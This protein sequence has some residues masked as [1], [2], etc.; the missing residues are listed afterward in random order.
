MAWVAWV[1]CMTCGAVLQM[2]LQQ[3][4]YT[5]E[6]RRKARFGALQRL[7]EE[8]K[9]QTGFIQAALG[10]MAPIL[11]FVALGRHGKEM[12]DLV[13]KGTARGNST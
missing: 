6:H 1:T 13:F 2:V 8:A 3:S 10:D 9:F 12:P 11:G 5:Q 7:P 4:H